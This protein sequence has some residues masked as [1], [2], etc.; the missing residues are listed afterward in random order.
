MGLEVTSVLDTPSYFVTAHKKERIYLAN[1]FYRTTVKDLDIT[2]S[3]E[4]QEVQF[5]TVEEALQKELFNNVI[6]FCKQYKI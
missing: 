4:C 1:I 5:F 3:D 6:E 2:P